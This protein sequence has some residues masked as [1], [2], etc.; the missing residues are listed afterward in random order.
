MGFDVGHDSTLHGVHQNQNT[1]IVAKC[2]HELEDLVL[3]P[4]LYENS[5]DVFRPTADATSAAGRPG[6]PSR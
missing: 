2:L 4:V 6:A 3:D 1:V 5:I